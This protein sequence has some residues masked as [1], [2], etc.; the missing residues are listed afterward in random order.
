ML[1]LIFFSVLQNTII[2]KAFLIDSLQ[3]VLTKTK[4]YLEFLSRLMLLT[5]LHQLRNTFI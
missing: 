2:L 1:I 5:N 3:L 4:I